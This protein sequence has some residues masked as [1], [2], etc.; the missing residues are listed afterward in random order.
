MSSSYFGQDLYFPS[1]RDGW[2]VGLIW[3][4][5]TVSVAGGILPLVL[6]GA[7]W[8]TLIF[9][10]SLLFVMDGLMLWVL[11]GTGYTVKSD[12]LCI[13]CGPFSFRIA[14][15]DIDSITPTQSPW[16]SPACSLDRLNVVYGLSGQSMMVSPEDKARFLAAIVEHCPSLILL[17][18]QVQRKQDTS[19]FSF[20]PEP[21][22]SHTL[23]SR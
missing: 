6:T 14:L 2:I 23:V 7:S 9:V 15:Q 12:Q 13:R 4:G 5:V 17:H 20:V 1:K 18:N 8:L 16:S 11:Y 10:G 21:R 3:L 22:Q 19:S